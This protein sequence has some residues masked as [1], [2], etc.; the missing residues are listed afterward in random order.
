MLKTCLVPAAEGRS[1]PHLG[2][3]PAPLVHDMRHTHSCLRSVQHATFSNMPHKGRALKFWGNHL[4][5]T[6][7]LDLILHLEYITHY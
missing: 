5:S 1:L 2:L 4:G 7:F 6:V 3:H